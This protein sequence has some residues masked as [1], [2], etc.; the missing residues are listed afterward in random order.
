MPQILFPTFISEM[1]RPQD[2]PKALAGLAGMS[3]AL[4]IAVPIIGYRFVPF[5]RTSRSNSADEL[6]CSYLGQYAEAP[7]FGS[8]QTVYKKAG[9]AFV[10]V[11]T[12]VIGVIYCV[13]CSPPLLYGSS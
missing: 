2:F 9:F 5:P 4:F 3:F 11:P 1:E 12:I 13:S 10:I 7:S 8:L 6:A